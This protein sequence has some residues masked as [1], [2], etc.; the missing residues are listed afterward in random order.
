MGAGTDG[1][2]TI[3]VGAEVRSMAIADLVGT[4]RAD[5]GTTFLGPATAPTRVGINQV[6]SLPTIAGPRTGRLQ[7]AAMCSIA[8]TRNHERTRHRPEH[9]AR[10]DAPWH[11]RTA[12]PPGT[13]TSRNWTIVPV[14][15]ANP[16]E[17]ENGDD[18]SV[19]CALCPVRAIAKNE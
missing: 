1:A 10:T 11:T 14:G 2:G 3:L 13:S 18:V 12:P 15:H 19:R 6:P 5:D 17:D 4:A 9:S 8:G 16:Y 7:A